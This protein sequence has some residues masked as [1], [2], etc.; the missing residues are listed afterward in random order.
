MG[1]QSGPETVNCILA[2]ETWNSAVWVPCPF[3]HGNATLLDQ[4]G[5]PMAVRLNRLGHAEAAEPRWDTRTRSRQTNAE[6]QM[7]W[8][9]LHATDEM[10]KNER[11]AEPP[12]TDMI[13]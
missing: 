8:K 7:T 2:E 9:I 13:Q 1:S 5:A 11:P 3:G 6:L 12:L 4:M 10:N